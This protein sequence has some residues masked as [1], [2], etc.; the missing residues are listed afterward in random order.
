MPKLMGTAFLL[1]M[2]LPL[3]FGA[4]SSKGVQTKKQ[5]VTVAGSMVMP[6]TEKLAEH[7]TDHPDFVV[8]V[9]G[10]GST[11]GF[12]MHEQHRR[13]WYVFTTVKEWKK[14]FI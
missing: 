1:L 8:D 10:G 3:T 12:S 5:T 7:F 13:Y 11:V 4:C 6:F 2:L 9:Q 14:G